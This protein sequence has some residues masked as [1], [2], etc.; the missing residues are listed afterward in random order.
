[1]SVRVTYSGHFLD[2]SGYGEAARRGLAA[3]WAAHEDLDLR[4]G[5]TFTDGA[6]K[7]DAPRELLGFLEQ[8]P[9]AQADVHLIH[10][11]AEHW[12][13]VPR[14]PATETVGAT[15]WETNTPHPKIDAGLRS[16]DRLLA[17]S[18]ENLSLFDL[19]RPTRYAPFPMVDP[20]AP[21]PIPEIAEILTTLRPTHVFYSIGTWQPRKNHLGMLLAT[22]PTL[23]GRT[24][25]L[26]II[27]TN[28]PELALQQARAEA[29]AW[30]R[31]MNLPRHVPL[32]VIGRVTPENLAW[33]HTV[34][35]CYVTL[36][37]GEGFNLPLADALDAGAE[38]IAS[39]SAGC[40]LLQDD[41]GKTLNGVQVI[42]GQ[43]MP[44]LGNYE[45]YDA[46]M[47]WVDPDIYQASRAVAAVVAAPPHR[48]SRPMPAFALEA[49]GQRWADGLRG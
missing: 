16:V 45:F 6:P 17:A 11:S 42:A 8:S 37:R 46:T 15:C 36:S 49:C 48:Y 43:S 10:S 7:I 23:T 33:L 28:L 47:L 12:P 25:A 39:Q 18:W 2:P 38:V 34:G 9:H 4:P 35:T 40:D 32:A 31:M 5:L 19:I 29:T 3:L 13:T 24:D 14:L 20:P 1:M 21:E 41:T 26:V 22:I 27:Q 30:L 44:V